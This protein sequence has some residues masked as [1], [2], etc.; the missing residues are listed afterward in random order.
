MLKRHARKADVQAVLLEL[1]PENVALARKAAVEAELP[2]LH[3]VQTDASMSDEYAPYVPADIVLACGIFG[4]ISDVDLEGTVRHLSMLCAE[5]AA[6]IWTRHWK[7]PA[8]IDSIQRWF[9]ESGFRNIRFDALDND[10]K[11]GI[12]LAQLTGP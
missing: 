7:E 8:V 3:V 5:G 9:S 1:D 4:N 6:V 10:R 11:M 2:Q 12:G